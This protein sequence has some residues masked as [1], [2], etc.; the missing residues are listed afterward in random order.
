MD[1]TGAGDSFC[2][3]VAELLSRGLDLSETVKRSV[4]AAALSTTKHGAQNSMPEI[5]EVDS[6]LKQI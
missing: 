4:V 1:T 3:S 5:S 2:G 6:F